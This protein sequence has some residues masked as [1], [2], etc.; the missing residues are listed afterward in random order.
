MQTAMQ[1][2]DQWQY[3]FLDKA[4]CEKFLS[5]LLLFIILFVY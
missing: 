2:Q 4:K 5:S 3:K 1:K